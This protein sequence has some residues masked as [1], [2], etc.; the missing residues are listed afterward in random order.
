[1][2]SIREATGNKSFSKVCD[3]E[4]W[5][6]NILLD[7]IDEAGQTLTFQREKNACVVNRSDPDSGITSIPIE[8]YGQGDTASTLQ[9]SEKNPQVI[10][11]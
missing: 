4:V 8:S 11:L 6:Q 7:Y 1:M 10:I 2:E 9:H 3:S 5:P